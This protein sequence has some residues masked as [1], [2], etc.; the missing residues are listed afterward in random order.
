MA[1][2]IKTIKNKSQAVA[3]FISPPRAWDIKF[4]IN[5]LCV[6]NC[7]FCMFHNDPHRLEVKDIDYFLNLL[8]NREFGRII[9][10]GGEPTLHPHFLDICDYLKERF[11]GR[12]SLR[13]GTN[14]ITL[15]KNSPRAA[16][17]RSKV[18]ETFDHIEV[19]CDDEHRNIDIV[20]KLAPIIIDSGIS[21]DLNVLSAYCSE[22]IRRRIMTL[23]SRCDFRLFFSELHH[24]Y[25]DKPRRNNTSTRC[26]NRVRSFL[27]NCDGSAF[28]CFQQEMAKPLFNLASVTKEKMEYYFTEYDPEPYQYCSCCPLYRPEI[29][30][31]SPTSF[32]RFILSY[33]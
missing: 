22:S 10:N 32:C 20:E 31:W 26:R 24:F 33:M 9:I 11:R 5:G 17:M 15:S 8:G 3:H 4:K 2:F 23:R 13:L 27:L 18:F 6:N 16:A 19:G 29:S 7:S 25:E 21:F 14:L 28:Y 1:P 30:S 12:I